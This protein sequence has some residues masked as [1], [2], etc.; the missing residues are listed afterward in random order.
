MC[1]CL[2]EGSSNQFVP[3]L[4]ALKVEIVRS[5]KEAPQSHLETAL[6]I[7]QS[8]KEAVLIKE[9]F[10]M[11]EHWAQ[12]LEELKGQISHQIAR[13][14]LVVH[15]TEEFEAFTT[16]VSKTFPTASVLAVTLSNALKDPRVTFVTRRE[17]YFA[18]RKAMRDDGLLCGIASG[19]VLHAVKQHSL[20]QT[21]A[22]LNDSASTYADTLLDDDW[23]L[24]NDIMDAYA[25]SEAERK[26]RGA[27]VEDLQLP[28]AV[29]VYD[30]QPATDALETMM[31]RDFSQ[32][33]VV[34][35]NRK[36]VGLIQLRALEGLSQ[37]DL[38]LPIRR[39]MHSFSRKKTTPYV[40]VTP[41]TPLAELEQFFEN[42]PAA[43]VTDSS[44]KFPLGIVTKLDLMRFVSRRGENC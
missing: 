4:K 2:P 14:A 7:A 34:N 43:I 28:A 3:L 19:A 31:S 35:S 41:A 10:G 1:V 37:S 9:P 12:L 18:A 17:A 33:P 42:H 16:C 36:V 40:V 26:Y 25:N 29:C 13:I 8:A 22:I 32:L 38:Q 44:A 27:S 5:H 21:V 23:L 15:N 6:Q 11:I 39:W 24:D 20:D 30:S